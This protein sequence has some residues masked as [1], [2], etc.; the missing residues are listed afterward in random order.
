MWITC[1]V[2]QW[3]YRYYEKRLFSDYE[4]FNCNHFINFYNFR[5]YG[6]FILLK[7]KKS[8][9]F[10]RYPKCTKGKFILGVLYGN[11]K[12]WDVMPC[13]S[14]T[15]YI[16]EE[17]EEGLNRLCKEELFSIIKEYE[18]IEKGVYCTNIKNVKWK[19]NEEL[20]TGD[21]E[22][23][24]KIALYIYS[25]NMNDMKEFIQ[26]WRSNKHNLATSQERYFMKDLVIIKK[27]KKKN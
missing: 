19:G 17:L 26:K 24:K 27:N 1:S 11:N 10:Y 23:G 13:F 25:D 16:G 20:I 8:R 12:I 22:K 21:D 4:L 7:C 15:R 6:D 2:P 3:D 18:E 5:K 9:Q 14:E